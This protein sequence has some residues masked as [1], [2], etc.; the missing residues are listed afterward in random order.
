VTN[1]TNKL[2]SFINKQNKQTTFLHKQTKQTNN[3]PS[4]TNKIKQTSK[5][6]SFINKQNKTNK[7]TTFL[8]KQTIQN[9]QNKQTTFLHRLILKRQAAGVRMC[10]QHCIPNPRQLVCFFPFPYERHEWQKQGHPGEKKNKGQQF[11]KKCTSETSIVEKN[12]N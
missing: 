2:P 11:S 10:H 3:L 5:Q 7:Q 6:H 9:R 8:R 1:K 12:I 4:K